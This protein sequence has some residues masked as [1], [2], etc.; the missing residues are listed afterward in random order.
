M[1][2]K[3]VNALNVRIEIQGSNILTIRSTSGYKNEAIIP[4]IEPDISLIVSSIIKTPS[5]NQI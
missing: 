1:S 5:H 3:Y 2:L 4:K